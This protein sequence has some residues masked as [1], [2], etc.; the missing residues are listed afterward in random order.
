M[1]AAT[2]KARPKHLNLFQIKLP[3]PGIVSIL[4]RVSGAG[5]FLMLPFLLWLL[6]ASLDS[7]ESWSRF[8][9]VTDFWLVKLLL[10][11]LLWAFLHHFFAGLRY[12]VLDLHYGTELPDARASSWAVFATSLPLTALLGWALW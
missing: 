9:A 8:T 12:L 10:L 5:L 7:P 11:G 1:T 2:A 3:L 4:H 6:Q